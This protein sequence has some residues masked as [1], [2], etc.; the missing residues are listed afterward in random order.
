MSDHSHNKVLMPGQ[1]PLTAIGNRQS[2]MIH[3]E[4]ALGFW[5]YLMSDAIIFAILFANYAVLLRGVAGGP[6]PHEVFELER[7]AQ[8]TGL[9]LTSSLTFGL[10]SISALSGKVNQALIWLGITFALGACFFYLEFQEFTHMI[11]HGAG[12]Q[13]SGF[14]SGFFGL[15]GTHGLHVLFGMLM[16]VVMAVQFKVKGLTEA[17]LSRLYRVGLFWLFLDIIWIGIFTFVYL[18]GVMQ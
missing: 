16:L 9:L 10:I 3:T 15:V 14:L 17:V 4:R 5:F 13:V 18:P 7:A 11:E 12:P 6:Q 1:D 8:Q 2:H